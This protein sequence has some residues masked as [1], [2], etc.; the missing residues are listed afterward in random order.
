M[1]I[2]TGRPSMD[3][4]HLDH[5]AST[6]LDPAVRAEMEPYLEE[7]FGNPSSRHPA[8]VRA[9]EALDRARRQVAR[10]VAARPEGVVLT[11]GGT[12]SNH[13]AVLGLA[14]AAARAGHV[15]VGPTEH[16]STRG[17]ARA[18]EELGYEVEALA[19]APD[20]GLDL[21][22]AAR[23][24]RP[25]TLLVA[26]VLVQSEVG[27][28][29]P[30]ARLARL[31]RSR[32]PRVRVHVDAVQALG[33]LD[34]SLDDLGA[35]TLSLSAHKVHG[36]KGAGALVVREGVALRPLV[37]GG[38]QEHG[39]RPGTQN[40]AGAVGLGAAAERADAAL[41]ATRAHLAALKEAFARGLEGVPGAR[42]L[43][44]GDESSSAIAAVHFDG[45]PAEVRMHHL[46]ARG[47]Y[48]SAGT[49]C[50]AR[51]HE[52][53]P[54]WLALGLAPEAARRV[55]RVSFARTTTLDEVQRAVQALAEV[56]RELDGAGSGRRARALP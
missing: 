10:A 20:G 32:A 9:A 56:A 36:P 54:T 46:E 26:Q 37:P 23:R 30:V 5:A 34:L 17:A 31:A 43:R 11:S 12:E 29:Y 15:L 24:V 7:L 8:G 33:K 47:V 53:S 18:L 41:E 45:A 21:E 55:L 1:G 49:A 42:L 6:R 3:P 40:V 13:L 44:A 14:R 48:V 28:V 25:D 2:L 4:I 19:L 27:T 52:V 22:D 51:S 39:L 50:Q 38:G 16:P 35:D